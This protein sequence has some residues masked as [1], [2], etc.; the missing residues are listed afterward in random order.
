MVT[1]RIANAL[2]RLDRIIVRIRESQRFN[3]P[4]PSTATREWAAELE[5]IKKELREATGT[6]PPAGDPGSQKELAFRP[7]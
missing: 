3:Q 1:E 4:L 7:T 2:N 5:F 6:A